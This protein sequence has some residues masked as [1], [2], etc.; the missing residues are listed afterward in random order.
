MGVSPKDYW[1]LVHKFMGVSPK[2]PLQFVSSFMGVSPKD[3]WQ[4]VHKFMG[5][6]LIIWQFDHCL[7]M[8]LQKIS[9]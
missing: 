9:L 1:Q 7:L 4:F 6:S 2:G 8:C 5:V 3:H